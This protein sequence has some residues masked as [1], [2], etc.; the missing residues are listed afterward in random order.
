M[1]KIYLLFLLCC[2]GFAASAQHLYQPL[3]QSAFTGAGSYCKDAAASPLS[4]TFDICAGG[5]GLPTGVPCTITW[6]YNLTNSTLVTGATFVTSSGF[7]CPLTPTG[8]QTLIPPTSVAGDFYYFCVISWSGGTALCAG[9]PAGSITSTTQLIHITAPLGAITPGTAGFAD[10]V[11]LGSTLSLSNPAT[12]GSWTSSNASVASVGAS[13]GLVTGLS[14]G[15]VNITY[16]L[17]GCFTTRYVDV[18]DTPATIMPSPAPAICEGANLALTN[19]SAGGTWLS[20]G[21]G[22]TTVS[23]T[24]MVTGNTA[25]TDIITYR[26]PVSQCYTR[27]AITVNPNPAPISGSTG[28]CTSGT[29]TLSDVSSPG[30]W[31]SSNISIASV[32]SSSGIV[33]GHLAGTV[34][35][36]FRYTGTGCFATTIVTVNNPPGAITGPISNVCAGSTF[37]LTELSPGG[38]WS[39]LLPVIAT[40]NATGAVTGISPGIDTIKYTIPGCASATK[41]I[42]VNPLPGPIAGVFTACNGTTISLTDI[43]SG[44][45]WFSSDTSIAVIDTFSGILTGKSMGTTNVTYTIASG[46]SV[47]AVVTVYPLA[48]IVGTDTICVGSTASL[49]NIVGGGTW[50]SSNPATAAIGSSSG[51]VTGLVDGITFI[52]Y[53]LP[54][55]CSTSFFLRVLP[56]LPPIAGSLEVCTGTVTALSDLATG[57]TWSTNNAFVADIDSSG[58]MSGQFPDTT[59]ISYSVYGCVTHALVTVDPLPNPVL[60]YNSA[61]QALSTFNYYTSYQWFDSTHGA[62]PGATNNIYIIPLGSQ[63]YRVVVTD[64][65]GCI[66]SSVYRNPL[67]VSSLDAASVRIFPNP[68][69]DHVF[70]E[71]PKVLN[72]VV[73][74]IDGKTLLQKE[75]ATEIDISKLAKGIYM[76]TLTDDEGQV[77]LARK[78]LKE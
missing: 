40:V 77:V 28:I 73:S 5:V 44:G 7:L 45:H 22:I 64:T 72:V 19:A 29:T 9:G 18:R 52:V 66:N 37:T 26:F 49:T 60:S 2:F 12:G 21:S 42:T 35:I 56:P 24:G 55:T 20:S 48:P 16:S 3:G 38:S 27:R 10:S 74:S 62:I 14:V 33:T 61:T 39:S 47:S 17:G 36:A 25:G 63:F 59:T 71:A 69:T 6:Y 53:T 68:A 34:T 41:A 58:K 76:M 4:F 31:T 65:N 67:E 70:I 57:G 46:C 43:S 8:T 78:L 23:S 50:A 75:H 13:S 30:T 32:G 1:K 11:C 54:T 51:I 15:L